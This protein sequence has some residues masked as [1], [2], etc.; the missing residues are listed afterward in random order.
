MGAGSAGG[1][2]PPYDG[3]GGGP[4]LPGFPSDAAPGGGAYPPPGAGAMAGVPPGAPF[5][6]GADGASAA[7]AGL[8]RWA[9]DPRANGAPPPL[10]GRGAYGGFD[11]AAHPHASPYLAFGHQ[12][13]RTTDP[14][15]LGHDCV[16]ACARGFVSMWVAVGRCVSMRAPPPCRF[17]MPD[18]SSSVMGHRALSPSRRKRLR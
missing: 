10:A 3:P 8:A 6:A 7:A 4:P 15:T 5:A 18:E 14:Q 13:R 17:L 2:P 9:G 12:V 11:E 16:S 1:P